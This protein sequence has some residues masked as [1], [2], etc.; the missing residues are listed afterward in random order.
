[1]TPNDQAVSHGAMVP[2]DV[3]SYSNYMVNPPPLPKVSGFG[4]GTTVISD[5]TY[6]N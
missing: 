5:T 2:N 4:V 3:S 6:G 1:M